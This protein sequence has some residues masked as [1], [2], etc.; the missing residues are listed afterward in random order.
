VKQC[1][2]ATET[3]NARGNTHEQA[4]LFFSF[5][6]INGSLTPGMPEYKSNVVL[7]PLQLQQ[8]PS[9]TWLYTSAMLAIATGHLSL[10]PLHHPLQEAAQRRNTRKNKKNHVYHNSHYPLHFCCD[11]FNA[12]FTTTFEA[13]LI[14]EMMTLQFD[15]F[16][17]LHN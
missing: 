14:K 15:F 7:Y 8:G 12:A 1:C 16:W 13:A 4:D 3:E 9:C 2:P 10:Q 11:G 6:L 5:N 17:I